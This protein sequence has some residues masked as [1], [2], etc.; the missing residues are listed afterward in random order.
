MR[1]I[2]LVLLMS[3]VS[4]VSGK[5]LWSDFSVSYLQGSNYR[6]GDN[7]RKVYTFEHVAGTNWGDSFLFIDRL[8]SDNGDIET[9][10]EWSPR[11]KLMELDNRLVK[12]LSLSTTVEMGT[13]AGADFSGFSFTNYLVGIGADLKLPHFKFFKVNVYHRNNDRNDNN[14]QTTFVW[15]L[16]IAGFIYDGFLDY[17]TSTDNLATSVNLTSQLKYDIAPHFNIT[18]ALFLGVEY[19]YWNNKF[20]IKNID[21]RNV[22]LL[23]K[24]HF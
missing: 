23:I 18:S 3:M 7:D 14:Y 10:G 6:V 9:Y 17:A 5:T 8:S 15:A 20:G 16:P 21:E 2:I 22:N 4:T 11:I 24:Y 13:F 1:K 12:D 19:V